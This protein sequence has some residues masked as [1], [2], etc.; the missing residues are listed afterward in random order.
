MYLI[1][2]Q[3]GFLA[4]NKLDGF[5]HVS[6]LLLLLFYSRS[7]TSAL[8]GVVQLKSIAVEERQV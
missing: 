6:M 4:R 7:E 3:L 2:I 5:P 1:Y 8:G